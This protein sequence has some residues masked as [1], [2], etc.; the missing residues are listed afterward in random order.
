MLKGINLD[1]AYDGALICKRVGSMWNHV[2]FCKQFKMLCS[3]IQIG[4]WVNEI[5]MLNIQS[6]QV[7]L[8]KREMI[9]SNMG[10]GMD[11][12]MEYKK[13]LIQKVLPCK[14]QEALSCAGMQRRRGQI[15]NLICPSGL[16]S[17]MPTPADMI[18]SPRSSSMFCVLF[19]SLAKRFLKELALTQL[20]SA[21]RGRKAT[22]R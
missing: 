15:M 18:V 6:F 1:E 19:P 3:Y 4:I 10:K 11:T 20:A 9:Q 22:C 12:C 16:D 17:C 13:F 5:L 21:R 14:G 2:L 8:E 7:K